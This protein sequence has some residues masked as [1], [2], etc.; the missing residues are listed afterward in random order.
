MRELLK[1]ARTVVPILVFVV[2]V[3]GCLGKVR[4]AAQRAKRS[5][6]LKEIGL[7]CHSFWNTKGANK[8]AAPM[9]VEDLTSLSQDTITAVQNGDIVVIWGVSSADRR[10][11]DLGAGTSQTILA[12]EKNAPNNG[13]LVLF[14]DGAVENL[15][16]ADFNAKAKAKATG[17]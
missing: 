16:A 7:A 1:R 6:Q 13:G 8:S 5:N 12:Y 2:L 15:T 4:E 3:P 10:A 9:K 11:A 14:L 17:K